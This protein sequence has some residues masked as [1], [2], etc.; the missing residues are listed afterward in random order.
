MYRKQFHAETDTDNI[1]ESFNHALR[2][3]YLH[4]QQDKTV[5]A[6]VKVLVDVVFK[7]QEREYVIAITQQTASYRIPRYDVPEYLR[8]RPRPVQAACLLNMERAKEINREDVTEVEEGVFKVKMPNA[9]TYTVKIQ[10]G[11]CSCH[12]F[13][14]KRHPCKHM[15]AVFTY[16]TD[17]SWKSLPRS[18][19]ESEY[20]TLDTCALEAAAVAPDTSD[21]P[22]G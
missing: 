16:F 11:Q 1:T 10:D 18:L 14:T 9:K 12:E 8:N 4:L 19:T 6:L 3:R 21:P 2:S 7:E 15:F 13:T 22:H 5:S 17:W 20:L